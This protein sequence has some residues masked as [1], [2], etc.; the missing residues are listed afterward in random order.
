MKL[1]NFVA[2]YAK[3]FNK[4][5]IETNKKR[6]LKNGYKKHTIKYSINLD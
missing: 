2:K 5:T 3:K 1:N 4:A 6:E